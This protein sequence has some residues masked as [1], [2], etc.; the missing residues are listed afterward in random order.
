M[1]T[2]KRTSTSTAVSVEGGSKQLKEFRKTNEA[3]GLRVQEGHLSLLSRKIFN[4]MMYRAQEMKETGINSP[5]DTP[6]S[7]KYFWMPL[8]ELARDAAYDSKDTAQLKAQIEEIQNIKLVMENERQWTS[9]RLLSSV[10]IIKPQGA[11]TSPL[12]I[13]FAFPPEVHELVMQPGTYTKLSIVYQGKLR[14]NASLALYEVCRRYL[15]NPSQVTMQE[16]YE[17]WH[18]M[19]TGNPMGQGTLAPYKYF[20]RD[21]LRKAIA[22]INAVTDI[23]VELIEH[24]IGNKVDKIQFRVQHARQPQLDFPAPPVIDSALVEQVM[25]F[26]LT[27]QESLDLVAQYGDSNIRSSI[28]AM[29][30]RLANEG[31][32]PVK[33]TKGYFI[34]LCKNS[35]GVPDAAEPQKAQPKLK[36]GKG[37]SSVMERFLSARARDALDVFNDLSDSDKSVLLEACRESVGDLMAKRMKSVDSAM[38]RSILGRWYAVQLW[39]E[40][41]ADD[42]ARFVENEVISADLDTRK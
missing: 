32:G 5:T 15:T 39:G 34:W 14:S 35:A 1:A 38:T 33:S 13:G 21:V 41:S 40:P 10:T 3:I 31:T 17:V 7:R 12:W 18:G 4:V 42:V 30:A 23:Q 20:K 9:E 2:K 8:A 27:K 19:L 11:M 22:E 6:A 28:Q 16:S 37:A 24:K 26:G 25:E 29:R 36:S